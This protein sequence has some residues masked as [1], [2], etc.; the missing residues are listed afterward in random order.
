MPIA[1]R[2]G[3]GGGRTPAREAILDAARSLFASHG[4][5]GTTVRAIAKSSGLSNTLLY[6][7][8]PRKDDLLEA[9]L[10]VP[11]MPPPPVPEMWTPEAFAN[12][13]EY[14]EGCFYNWTEPGDFL[15]MLIIECYAGN[16]R[17]IGVSAAELAVYVDALEPMLAV[18]CG[19]HEARERALSLGYSLTGPPL[20]GG[21]APWEALPG[22]S[23][24]R[25][26]T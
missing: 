8:F 1:T 7:Y 6:Y 17:C 2:D 18:A 4:I 12:A 13:L 23:R 10:E 9:L 3:A 15:R 21:D 19:R 20:A 11:A 26:G 14:L 16:E 5:R 22:S 25:L 24:F